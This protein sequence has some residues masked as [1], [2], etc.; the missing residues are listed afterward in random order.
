MPQPFNKSVL[1]FP[2]IDAEEGII[3]I[4]KFVLCYCTQKIFCPKYN[5]AIKLRQGGF[6]I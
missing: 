2:T 4:V 3:A 1:S 5:R 6:L